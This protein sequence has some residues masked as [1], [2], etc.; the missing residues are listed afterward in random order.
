[1]TY[2]PYYGD[3][4]YDYHR[5]GRSPR[6]HFRG[7]NRSPQY[8]NPGNTGGLYR[9]RSHGASPQPVINNIYMD[10]MAD[11]HMR[12]ESPFRPSPPPAAA[13]PLP[14]PPPPPIA[15]PYPAA[16]PPVGVPYPV[17][18]SVPSPSPHRRSHSRSRSRLGDELLLEQ[19]AG[20]R[21]QDRLRSRSRGRTEGSSDFAEWRLAQ[22]ERELEDE[23]RRKQWEREAELDRI[24]AE[25]K[26]EKAEHDAEES[27][28]KAVADFEKRKR[29]E[30]EKAKAERAKILADIER[31]KAQAKEE[32]RRILEK[33]ERDK[34]EAKEEER[35]ILE[36]AER[37][38]R[39][40]KERKEREY[41][42]FL[43]MQKEKEEKAKAEQKAEKE[44]LDNAL[45]DRFR[46]MG[47]TDPQIDVLVDEEKYKEMQAQQ[48]NVGAPTRGMSPGSALPSFNRAP[49]YI[50]VHRDY[51]SPETLRYYEIPYESD[52]T[53]PNYIII[54]REMDKYETDVL[55]EHTRRLRAGAGKLFLEDQRK[56]GR[57]G[58][59]RKYAWYR[60]RE[61]SSSRVGKGKVGILEVRRVV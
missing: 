1:M 10:Q 15:M 30:A 27:R 43:R 47:Y 8:L 11:A 7:S 18:M 26:A 53:D 19:M 33:A 21:L 2:P 61:R 34:R 6:P 29:D 9:S 38:Q 5:R 57:G 39:E 17:P 32:E 36:K 51:L 49:V 3:D 46:K 35:R 13:V 37:E 25:Q 4:D 50:K 28:E 54:L 48:K 23:R 40:A 59:E 12:N 41:Q 52:R 56:A 20:L 16:Y 31:E 24:K 60:K 42:D 44:K 45:R 22:R 14:P 58:E 55:F